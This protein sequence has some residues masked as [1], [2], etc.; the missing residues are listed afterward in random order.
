MKLVENWKQSWRWWSIHLAAIGAA[1][2]GTIIAAPESILKAW[3]L[4]PADMQA[5]LKAYH[6]YIALAAFCLAIVARLI[7]QPKKGKK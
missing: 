1:I 7:E 2:T 4:L 6:G 5:S 3:A